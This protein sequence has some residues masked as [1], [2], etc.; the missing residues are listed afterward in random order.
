MERQETEYASRAGGRSV[1]IAPSGMTAAALEAAI[2]AALR[3][4]ASS[5]AAARAR[6]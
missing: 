5:V 3:A 1:S 6:E 4:P 2:I